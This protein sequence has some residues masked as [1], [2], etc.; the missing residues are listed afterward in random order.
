MN[1]SYQRYVYELGHTDTSEMSIS[2][3]VVLVWGL[4]IFE[5]CHGFMG[6]MNDYQACP[7]QH[8]GQYQN[9]LMSQLNE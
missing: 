1:N 3:I 4:A 9:G 2:N 7:G 8:Q 5:I 6:W